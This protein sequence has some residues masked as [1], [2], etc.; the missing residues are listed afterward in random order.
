MTTQ[1]GNNLGR[2]KFPVCTITLGKIQ[3]LWLSVKA[4]HVGWRAISPVLAKCCGSVYFESQPS[5]ICKYGKMMVNTDFSS[6]V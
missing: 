2:Y 3:I 5:L 6:P 1:G 4:I